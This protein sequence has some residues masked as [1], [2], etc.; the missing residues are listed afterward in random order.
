MSDINNLITYFFL[1]ISL[2]FEIFILITYFENRKEIKAEK[3]AQSNVKLKKY[4]SVTIIVPC[5]NEETTVS[6]TIHSLLNLDYPKDKLKIMVIDDGST[7]DTWSVVQKFANHPQIKLYTKENGGK[8][9]ALNYGI[10]KLTTDLVGCL[11]ADSYVHKDSMKKIALYFE[12]KETM[13]VAPSIKLWQPRNILQLLQKVEY[14]FGIFTR[15]M[16]HY[17]NA[18]YITP[19]PFSIFRREVF[20]K[21]GGYEHAHNTE[22]IQIALRMQK[23]GFKIAHAHDAIVYTIPPETVKKLLKQRVR[24]SYGFIKNAYD[25]RDMIFNKKYGNVGMLILPMAC[26]SIVSVLFVSSVSILSIINTTVNWAVRVQTVGI[27]PNFNLP[28]FDWF[29]V[30]TELIAL[31]G[32]VVAVGSITMILMSKRMSEDK[33]DIGMDLIYYLSLYMFIAPIWIGKAAWNA[34]FSVKT[35]WR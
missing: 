26:L 2:N 9:T 22:D 20:E 15:K 10:S 29:Y 13:A 12:D 4:P 31:V 8:Y 1:F 19:G 11:D 30:N 3:K 18:I 25:F 34:I 21:L 6:K 14:G 16:Y 32:T 28:S 5:W 24:W 17:M 33:F 23:N 27:N 35:T 7:D